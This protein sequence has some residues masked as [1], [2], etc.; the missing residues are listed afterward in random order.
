MDKPM[1]VDALVADL[2]REA[3]AWDSWN[4]EHP[5]EAAVTTPPLLRRAI[6]AIAHQPAGDGLRV[7]V[8]GVGNSWEAG[9]RTELVLEGV[10]V[11]DGQRIPAHYRILPAGDAEGR[12]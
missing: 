12:G 8:I 7:H 9:G 6:A 10:G 3:R 2:D 4:A 1:T 11:F 5:N